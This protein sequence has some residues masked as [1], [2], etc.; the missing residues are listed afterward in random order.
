MKIVTLTKE[1]F[2][3][4]SN[5]HKFNTFYQTPNYAEFMKI[6][7]KFNIHY[8]GF[9][10]DNN[11]LIGAS[12]MLYKT[13]FWGYK[14]AYSPRGLLIDYDDINMVT[15][16]TKE[17]K[18]L[19]KKQKF[20][21]ITVDPPII[22]SERDKD[23]NKIQTNNNINN[24]LKAF[25]KLDYEHLGFNLY[26]ES[27]LPRWNVIAPLNTNENIMYLNFN[28]NI[29]DDIT[30]A[31]SIS[32]N[33][34][35]DKSIDINAFY[36]L[37][38]RKYSKKGK[39]YFDNLIKSFPNNAKI[40]YAILDTKKYTQNANKLYEKEEEK[41]N[42]LANII[43]SGDNIKYNIQKAINDK[44]SSDKLLHS[45]KK[46]VVASTKLLKSN[47]DG[48]ILGCALTIE[49]ANGVNILVNYQDDTYERYHTNSILTFEIMKYFGK[50]K[51][52]YINLGS[53]TGNF[54]RTSKYYQTLTN[55]LGF[56]SS[57]LEYIGEFNMILNPTMYRIYKNKY[58]KK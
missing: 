34:I 7:D 58:Q 1:E 17:L 2:E 3:D 38:K 39:K 37:I 43:Q 41:N 47:P 8:L 52:K 12:L 51:Y 21:F 33:V 25:K 45:Y 28:D 54:D 19:L 23:G 56:N 50:Q 30:Y 10:D 44:L 29:K 27:I 26:D 36:E 5:K 57:I 32:I 49:E 46:D 22:T 13:L 11:N 55:K 14:Y 6:N 24:I 31:R 40:F 9:M 4:F 42:T 18:K 20:I 15:I 53:V 16:V 48:L 35:N